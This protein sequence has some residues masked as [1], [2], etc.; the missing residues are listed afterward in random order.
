MTSL[1]VAK[2]RTEHPT[3]DRSEQRTKHLVVVADRFSGFCQ[4]DRVR[5][6]SGLCAAIASGEFDEVPGELVLHP[7]Q[8]ITPYEQRDIE[9]TV[10]RRGLDG[11]LRLTNDNLEPAGRGVVHK[12]RSENVLLTNL[13]CDVERELD[14]GH[15]DF[16]AQLCLHGHNEL[17]LDHQTGEH[18]QGL[19][20]VEAAR[21]MF[22]AAFELGYRH[23]WPLRS[24]YVVWNSVNLTFKNFLFP[25][26]AEVSG[27]LRELS[28]DDPAKLEYEMH[29][30]IHQGGCPVVVGEIGFTSFET[31]RIASIERRRA[32][33]ALNAC[34]REAASNSNSNSN[35]AERSDVATQAAR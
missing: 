25:L 8:G 1:P 28:I 32:K 33:Q 15:R 12:H 30:E 9:E 4:D 11:R 21:Q 13:C 35:S 16:T 31:G 10:S 34:I 7:G 27:T 18:V 17:L 14:T 19:V 2:A 24:Y 20:I 3:D 23:L 5:T 22:L 6:V 26:P 29:V